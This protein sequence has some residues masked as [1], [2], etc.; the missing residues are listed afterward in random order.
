MDWTA[1]QIAQLR[2]LWP[3]GLTTAEMG[4]R[5]HVTKFAVI[6]KAHRLGLP[7]KPSPIRNQDYAPA[8]AKAMVEW[9]A[10]GRPL[11]T[12]PPR[13]YAPPRE[14]KALKQTFVEPTPPP[15]PADR[16]AAMG[17]EAK[18]CEFLTG[19]ERPYKPCGDDKVIGK[20]FCPEHCAQSYIKIRPRQLDAA[21]AARMQALAD[22]AARLQQETEQC[23]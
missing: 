17:T 6:G 3:S 20:P 19:A 11:R 10:Q 23:L 13:P 8:R 4:K 16:Y 14:K 21:G 7:G 15:N 18:P 12:K 22:N 5:L 1:D 9:H 2:E